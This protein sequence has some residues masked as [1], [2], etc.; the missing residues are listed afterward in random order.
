MELLAPAGGFEQLECAVG[1]GADAVYLATN[2]YG[3]RARAENFSEADLPS[4]ISYAH[5]HGVKVHVAVNTMMSD[6][7]IDDLPRYFAFLEA[8]GADAAIVADLGAISIARGV[9]PHVAIHLST[10]ESCM[11]ARAAAAYH[12]LGVSRVV[13][14]REMSLSAIAEMRRR[15]PADMELEAFGHGSMCMAYSG[16]CLISD[17]L[18]G[19]DRSANK[20]NCSQ[21]CR[22]T[23]SLVEQTRPGQYFD[24]IEEGG[25]VPGRDTGALEQSTGAAS[26]DACTCGAGAS[27]VPGD[28]D[29]RAEGTNDDSAPRRHG[30]ADRNAVRV[31][32]RAR[33]SRGTYIMSS[34]DMCMLGHLREMEEAGID[35]IKIEGRAKGA[36]YVAT[37]VNAY[38]HVLDGEPAE[39]WAGELEAV[40]HRPYSTGFYFGDPGQNYEAGQYARAWQMVASGMGMQAGAEA[41]RAYGLTGMLDFAVPRGVEAQVAVADGASDTATTPSADAA[42]TPGAATAVAPTT[43]VTHTAFVVC[44]NRFAEGDEVQVLEPGKP[45]RTCTVRNL[46]WHAAP[47]IDVS[48]ALRPR[49]GRVRASRGALD[50]APSMGGRILDPDPDIPGGTLVSVPRANRTMDIY[51]FDAPFE[52][53][54]EAI[55]RKA[56]G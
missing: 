24:V 17:Y 13:V 54:P 19:P 55:V 7:D 6:A 48:E 27:G 3:M 14:A 38:R 26:D 51:S 20:G 52:V 45:V 10:Q 28:A 50:K 46:I 11:N 29:K 21:P 1:F 32:E 23:Y 16:R 30:D 37:V 42:A 47:S 36:Y 15:M 53:G 35:S 33:T 34:N 5:R 18:A 9:A 8:S 4:A 41:I 22:W 56:Q 2:R 49:V 12:A 44:R 39:A 25:P 40:S 31:G 43:A